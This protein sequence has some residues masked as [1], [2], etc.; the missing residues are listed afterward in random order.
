MVKGCAEEGFV[1]PST[2]QPLIGS[3]KWPLG[4]APRHRENEINEMFGDKRAFRNAMKCVGRKVNQEYGADFDRCY[5]QVG[6][7]ANVSGKGKKQ[8]SSQA[9][10]PQQTRQSRQTKQT[11]NND[12]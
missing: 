1:D 2:G 7:S 4:E 10:Q 8:S 9:Q 3:E 6:N 5:G 11:N 12:A